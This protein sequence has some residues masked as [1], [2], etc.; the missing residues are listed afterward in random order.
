MRSVLD[1][2]AIYI[3]VLKQKY[4]RMLAKKKQ[5]EKSED[6]FKKK[7]ILNTISGLLDM[8][9]SWLYYPEGAMSCSDWLSITDKC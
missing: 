9:H 4:E 7:F 1:N 8:E 2:P 3:K 5:V 6:T